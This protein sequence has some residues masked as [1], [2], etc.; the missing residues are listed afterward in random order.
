MPTLFFTFHKC[1]RRVRMCFLYRYFE[2]IRKRLRKSLSILVVLPIHKPPG[3]QK[4]TPLDLL[5]KDDTVFHNGL[6]ARI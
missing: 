5:E 1:M 4:M 2:T 6:Q 3:G